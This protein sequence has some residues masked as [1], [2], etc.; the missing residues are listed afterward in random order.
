MKRIRYI[1]A[2]FGRLRPSRLREYV[3]LSQEQYRETYYD[4]LVDCA[5][6]G[7]WEDAEREFHQWWASTHTRSD[8]VVGFLRYLLAIR[9]RALRRLE[10]GA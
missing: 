9:P 3:K 4:H 10:A 5:P 6:E 7:P 8:R 1:V 2:V